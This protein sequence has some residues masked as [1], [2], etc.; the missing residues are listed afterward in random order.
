MGS[1]IP[2]GKGIVCSATA[3]AVDLDAEEKRGAVCMQQVSG[4]QSRMTR[5]LSPGNLQEKLPPH[6]G[7]SVGHQEKGA[8]SPIRAGAGVPARTAPPWLGSTLSL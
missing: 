4:A 6:L 7:I 8:G 3:L 1:E 2:P 5:R